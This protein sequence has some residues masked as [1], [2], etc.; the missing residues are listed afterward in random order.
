MTRTRTADGTIVEF[1]T[2]DGDEIVLLSSVDHDETVEAGRI[3][4][5]RTGDAGFQPVPFAPF[6]LRPGALRAIAEHIEKGS[7]K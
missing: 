5:D 6:A 3:Y 7:T 1:V 2:R 4:R